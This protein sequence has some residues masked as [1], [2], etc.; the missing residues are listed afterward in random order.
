MEI[1][2]GGE[3]E[4]LPR[5]KGGREREVEERS[6]RGIDSTSP[7]SDFAFAAVGGKNASID[8][9]VGGKKMSLIG[10]EGR[11]KEVT[12][13]TDL[14]SRDVG[15]KRKER[16]VE[17]KRRRVAVERTN[18]SRF[19]SFQSSP[20]QSIGPYPP[21]LFSLSPSIPK[22]S[23]LE[24]RTG[25]RRKARR[26]KRRAF[27]RSLSLFRAISLPYI[28]DNRLESGSKACRSVFYTQ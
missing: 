15:R 24:R 16:E 11:M 3:R 27:P 1:G 26:L 20:P 9:A 10:R 5:K 18:V 4:S 22:L 6:R 13:W 8:P 14:A 7:Q 25:C 2:G 21:I 23:L 19:C 28:N 12:S 17:R